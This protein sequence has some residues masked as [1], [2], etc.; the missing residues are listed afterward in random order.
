VA[1]ADGD[2]AGDDDEQVDADRERDDQCCIDGQVRADARLGAGL[3]L[4]IEADR[5]ASP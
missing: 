1:H 4:A 3:L 2:L 5:S